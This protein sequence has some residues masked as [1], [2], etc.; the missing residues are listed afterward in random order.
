MNPA[1][2]ME[3]ED[4]GRFGNGILYVRVWSD[5]CLLFFRVNPDSWNETSTFFPWILWWVFIS[6]CVSVLQVCFP[7]L[8]CVQHLL[9]NV[10]LLLYL[11][12]HK[13]MLCTYL[14][15]LSSVFTVC[16]EVFVVVH[17]WADPASPDALNTLSVTRWTC[18]RNVECDCGLGL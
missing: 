7:N 9:N 17:T 18:S 8:C 2:L 11:N 4:L 14:S 16:H 15:C 10:S 13:M 3:N 6:M 12:C 1:E 5:I